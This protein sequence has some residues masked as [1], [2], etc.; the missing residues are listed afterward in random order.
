MCL[1]LSKC[2]P[3]NV[4]KLGFRGEFEMPGPL[5]CPHCVTG[6]VGTQ[7]ERVVLPLHCISSQAGLCGDMIS[8]QICCGDLIPMSMELVSGYTW[9]EMCHVCYPIFLDVVQ[10]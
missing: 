7:L 5:G 10:V 3:V 8:L 6:M 4:C 2:G 1:Q 9:N